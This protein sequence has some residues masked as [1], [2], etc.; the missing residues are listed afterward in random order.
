MKINDVTYE[1]LAKANAT[2]KTTNIKGKDYA[3]VNQ[4]IKAFRMVYP[5]G[6]IVTELLSD[7]NGRCVFRAEVS[8]TDDEGRRCI[9]GMGTAYERENSS[10]IN[11]TSYVENCETSAIG[12]ALGMAGFGIDTSVASYE[13]VA[14]AM[15]N[16]SKAGRNQANARAQQQ[17]PQQQE[18]RFASVKQV[19][20][21][22]KVYKG[23]TL[24][25]LL[26]KNNI[27]KLD[28]LPEQK[29]AELIE[30]LGGYK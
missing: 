8:I 24:K 2:I 12:R 15:N 28:E 1:T 19:A 7:D 26:R 5:T 11:K 13:E 23:E 30:K 29:A 18:F 20:F 22:E 4:R 14:N 3:E 16:Q 25:T 10:F 17:A 6:T 27:N 9:L 21:L